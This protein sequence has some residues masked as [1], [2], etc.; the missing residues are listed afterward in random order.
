[1]LEWRQA[2]GGGRIGALSIVR[3]AAQPELAQAVPYALG[4]IELDAGVRVFAHIAAADPAALRPGM[5]V[6]CRF[7]PTLDPALSVPVFVCEEC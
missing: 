5:R 6:A 3:R 7:E 1:M 2:T 4:F